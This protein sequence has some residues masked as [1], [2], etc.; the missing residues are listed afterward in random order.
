MERNGVAVQWSANTYFFVKLPKTQTKKAINH[1]R[2]KAY[3]ILK[4]PID[5]FKTNPSVNR[6]QLQSVG[7]LGKFRNILSYI[8]IS[9]TIYCKDRSVTKA[10]I[11]WLA[12]FFMSEPP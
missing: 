11:G 8:D 12:I 10:P 3:I 4:N 7:S 5:Y 9:N 6:P 1:T 2:N